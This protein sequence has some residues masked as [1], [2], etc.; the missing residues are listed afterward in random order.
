MRADRGLFYWRDSY[1]AT[2]YR[3]LTPIPPIETKVTCHGG[4]EPHSRL[5]ILIHHCSLS[6]TSPDHL[7]VPYNPPL[8]PPTD[9]HIPTP[10]SYRPS[11]H[12]R[13]MSFSRFLSATLSISFSHPFHNLA[14]STGLLG[15]RYTGREIH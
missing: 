6:R 4:T 3:T 5:A 15:K 2:A 1:K 10:I 7:P 8:Y 12:Y 11:L 14:A 9:T 13:Q